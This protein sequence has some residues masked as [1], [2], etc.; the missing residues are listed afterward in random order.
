M[1]AIGW[2]AGWLYGIKQGP[3]SVVVAAPNRKTAEEAF[4]LWLED[5]DISPSSRGV[6]NQ[7]NR[8]VKSTKTVGARPLLWAQV[9]VT[10]D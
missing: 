2:T 4:D 9:D 8:H 1:K 6:L 5:R 7:S 3:Y 10:E